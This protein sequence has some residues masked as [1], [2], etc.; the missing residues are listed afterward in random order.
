M[1][2][3]KKMMK[4]VVVIVIE[5]RKKKGMMEMGASQSWDSQEVAD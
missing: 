2:V 5:N 1:W 3:V 4:D